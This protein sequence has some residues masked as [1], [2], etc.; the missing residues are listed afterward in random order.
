MAARRAPTLGMAAVAGLLAVQPAPAAAAPT[1]ATAA[2]QPPP[3]SEVAATG[4]KTV[5]ELV[6]TAEKTVSELIVTAPLKCLEPDR[7]GGSVARAPQVVS[8][9]PQPGSTVRPGLVV[10]RVTF[11][12]PMGCY[13]AFTDDPPLPNPCPWTVQRM[14]LSL[15]R[16]TVRTVCVVA[17]NARYA[18]WM[19]RQVSGA[20]AFI[21][22]AGTR[23]RPYR[24]EFATS[25]G[26]SVTTVCDA[27]TEDVETAR[28]I[29]KRRKLDCSKARP[30]GAD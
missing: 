29:E 2:A 27:L 3:A 25:A 16:R 22:L 10:L 18:V 24:V 13:G 15:D 8:T 26:Q 9:F 12:L 23:L 7:T 17:P 4:G 30:P 1:P 20:D 5:S 28:E 14:Q 19:N 21:S 11:D 6:V